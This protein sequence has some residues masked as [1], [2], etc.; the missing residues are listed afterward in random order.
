M[1]RICSRFDILVRKSLPFTPHATQEVFIMS[2]NANPQYQLPPSNSSKSSSNTIVVVGI[3][4]AVV[5]GCLVL[6]G[7]ML[8]ALL[9]P[10]V[11]AASEA[12]RRMQCS[13]NLKQ[14][15]LALHNYNSANG[16]MPPAYTVDS[17]GN[18]LHSWRTLL[19]PY[20]EQ[21]ALYNQIDF[22]KPWDDPINVHLTSLDITVF[23]C[24]SS[25]IAPGMTTYQIVD[26][27]S[28]AFP[29]STPLKFTDIKDG[30]SNTLFA[31]ESDEQDAVH[32]A[33]PKDQSMQIYMSTVRSSHSG[34]RNTAFMDGS[35]RFIS[36]QTDSGF[37]KALVT[38]GGGEVNV[39]SR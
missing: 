18:R 10:A 33:E 19:L 16:S 29:G 2:S 8:A 34:G 9:I 14:I 31:I 32:W 36:E 3:I 22:S 15:A 30:L 37:S 24:P 13:N 27:P 5:F 4:L 6:C 28:S 12:A 17:D 7:G 39:E 1:C 35:V 21:S 26:D 38:A 23:R 11:Q 20:M 25:K